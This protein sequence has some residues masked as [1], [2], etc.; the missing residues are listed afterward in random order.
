MLAAL[1]SWLLGWGKV[2]SVAIINFLIDCINAAIIA[3][4]AIITA[5]ANLLP[6]GSSMPSLPQ[7]PDSGTWLTMIQTLNWLFPMTFI[8]SCFGFITAAIL[9]YVVIAPLARWAK[10]LR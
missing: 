10:L 3:L 7:V 8:V 2:F 9:A 5:I 6:S 1:T 4:V